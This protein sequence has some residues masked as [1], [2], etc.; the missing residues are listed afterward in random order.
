VHRIAK[1][2]T[3]SRKR[4]LDAVTIFQLDAGSK[5]QAISAEEVYVHVPGAAVTLE[6]E[7]MVLEVS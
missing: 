3:E 2:T 1:R 6:F 5:T 4:N 7:V